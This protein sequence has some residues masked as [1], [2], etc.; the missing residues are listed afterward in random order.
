MLLDLA[1]KALKSVAGGK[2]QQQMG[3]QS[4]H[5]P[6]AVDRIG[7]FLYS[8]TAGW[9]MVSWYTAYV[10]TRT[11]PGG[12]PKLVLPG[13]GG[14]AL[15]SPARNDPA[16]PSFGR[17]GTG[18]GKNRGVSTTVPLGASGPMRTKVSRIALQ[19]VGQRRFQYAPVRPIPTNILA[20]PDITDC[21]GF[22]TQVF[23]TAGAPDPNGLSFNRPLQGSSGDMWKQGVQVTTPN[24][25]D[26]VIYS[27]HV[28]I[29][30]S[31]NPTTVVGFGS[32]SDP[33]PVKRTK[34]E[35]DAI[36]RGAGQSLLGIRSYL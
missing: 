17:N 10:N 20:N 13:L 18:T 27:D 21:S 26:L 7:R 25:G 1:G 4:P 6:L 33:G 19:M 32:V 28:V 31:L 2:A 35:Q 36:Q 9:I 15:G 5:L 3:I 30:T 16:S 29:V 14:P 24:V 34:A 8:V 11:E 23:L 12:G 22:V